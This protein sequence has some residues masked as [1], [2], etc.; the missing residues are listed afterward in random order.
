MWTESYDTFYLHKLKR[1]QVYI[2][3]SSRV[4]LLLIIKVMIKLLYGF[5]S[6]LT[7][8]LKLISLNLIKKHS[9]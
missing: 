7:L 4:Q 8:I 5:K 2:M 3:P 6:K 9:H 1:I